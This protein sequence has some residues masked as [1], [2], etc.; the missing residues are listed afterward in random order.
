MSSSQL[1]PVNPIAQT[2]AYAATLSMHIP[3]FKQGE[4]SHSSISILQKRPFHP[5]AQSHVKSSPRPSTHW[6]PLWHLFPLPVQW[7]EIYLRCEFGINIWS[8]DY[9]YRKRQRRVHNEG[10]HTQEGNNK[11]SRCF[12]HHRYR[13]FDTDWTNIHLNF[14]R[15]LNLHWIKHKLM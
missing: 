15:N 1:R 4:L 9:L 13:H 8:V 5:G 10:L 14:P 7:M 2:H 3:P 12:Y 11:H 6:P